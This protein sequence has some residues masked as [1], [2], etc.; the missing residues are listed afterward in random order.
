MTTL[1]YTKT[2][3]T[4]ERPAVTVASLVE[5][6]AKYRAGAIVLG[7]LFAALDRFL[8]GDAPEAKP[9]KAKEKV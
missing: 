3:V 9:A 5:L 7:E 8:D 4:V 2:T 6:R 1:E